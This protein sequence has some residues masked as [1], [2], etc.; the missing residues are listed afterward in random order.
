MFKK[1]LLLCILMTSFYVSKANALSQF[2]AFLYPSDAPIL[3]GP[4][5]QVET[6]LKEEGYTPITVGFGR[7]GGMPTGKQVFAIIGYANADGTLVA[8]VETPAG[9]DKCILYYI[10]DYTEVD[11]VEVKE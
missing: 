9:N 2:P 8:T 11:K 3:C 1:I 10:F 6:F 7:E 5:D 4:Y